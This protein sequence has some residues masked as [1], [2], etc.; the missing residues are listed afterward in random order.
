MRKPKEY[1]GYRTRIRIVRLLR[2]SAFRISVY[3]GVNSATKGFPIDGFFQRRETVNRFP[4]HCPPAPDSP[5]SSDLLL[6]F[7]PHADRIVQHAPQNETHRGTHD[8]GPRG[9]HEPH[10]QIRPPQRQ[11]LRRRDNVPDDRAKIMLKDLAKFEKERV[12][13]RNSYLKKIISSR[14]IFQYK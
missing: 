5:P 9:G 6:G 1:S 12:E 10:E 3:Y 11:K 2:V 4:R 14:D 8:R 13:I 7:H